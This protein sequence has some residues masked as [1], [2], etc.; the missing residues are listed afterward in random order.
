MNCYNYFPGV[1]V[2]REEWMV[3]SPD[4]VKYVVSEKTS[5]A[6]IFPS[7]CNMLLAIISGITIFPK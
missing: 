6:D 4:L 7:I 3:F 2:R 1:K 5:G